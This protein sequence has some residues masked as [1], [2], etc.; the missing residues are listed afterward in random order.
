MDLSNDQTQF[1]EQTRGRCKAEVEQINN[2]IASEVQR[3]KDLLTN[4][5]NRKAAVLQ[6]YSAA[7]AVLG[8]EN[9]L[10]GE[11]GM[12]IEF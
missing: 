2:T 4:L 12:D 11:E 10:A 9:E 8:E 6:M 3:V 7:C 1:Y 5:S